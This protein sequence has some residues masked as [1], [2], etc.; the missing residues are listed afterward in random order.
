M[1][2]SLFRSWL[3]ILLNLQILK[4]KSTK[5]SLVS[6]LLTPKKICV[7]FSIFHASGITATMISRSQYDDQLETS[8]YLN[9]YESDRQYDVNYYLDSNQ[10]EFCPYQITNIRGNNEE[11]MVIIGS[12][13]KVH[14]FV[15][16][17]TGRLIHF[18]DDEDNPV[19][20]QKYGEV[21][22]E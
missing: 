11:H 4:D 13:K 10:L 17:E 14:V 22:E 16:G 20:E 8:Y 12:D 18:S 9:V 21:E 5:W 1:I 15:Y 3:S 6:N 2:L 7:P 19:T